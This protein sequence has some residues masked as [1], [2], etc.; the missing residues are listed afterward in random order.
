MSKTKTIYSPSVNILR[1]ADKQ[2]NY[3]VTANAQQ[4]VKS[5]DHS[6]DSGVHAFSIIGSY[7]TGKSSFLWAFEH[8]LRGKAEYFNVPFAKGDKVALI[9]MVGQNQSII[10]HFAEV[11][12]I[13]NDLPGNQ[14][15]F[16]ALFQRY[17]QC[18]LLLVAIDEFGKFLEH[19][20][21]HDP[22]KELYFVQQLAE[23][24]NDPN[25]KILLLTTLHQSFD[26]Y[27]MT[28]SQTQRMEWRKVKGRLTE[29][30]FNEP[31]EQLLHLA[32]GRINQSEEK[33]KE[34]FSPQSY[35][36]LANVH[37][38]F[39]F[40]SDG[41]ERCIER[42]YPLDIFAATVLTKALQ[43]YGQNERS[44]FGF[45]ESEAFEWHDARRFFD[46]ADVF[47]YLQA[48]FHSDLL[49]ARSII[50]KDW[51][52][53][54]T[55]LDLVSTQIAKDRQLVEKLVKAIGLL[56]LFG[57]KGAQLNDAFWNAYASVW[58][59]RS[60]DKALKKLRDHNIVWFS[61]LTQA[62]Q[63]RSGTDVD[64]DEALD[65][66][67]RQVGLVTEVAEKLRDHFD[68]P[69][70]A[71]KRVSYE[72]GT[73]R[74]FD[75]VI[76]EQPVDME[77]NGA[78][79]GYINLVIDP[80]LSIEELKDHSKK[81]LGAMLF[82]HFRHSEQISSTLADI[83]KTQLAIQQHSNDK[84]A[85]REFESIAQH[86]KQLLEHYVI[87][88]LYSD[89]VTWVFGGKEQKDIR[90]PKRFNRLL[91]DICEEVYRG[92]PVFRSELANRDKVSG[93]ISTARKH[94][95][96]RL[97][98][99]WR[100]ENLGFPENNYPAEK[101]IYLS[102][103]QTTGLHA[104]SDNGYELARPMDETASTWEHW[105]SFIPL[106]EACENFLDET[107]E[108]K[109]NLI[110]LYDQLAK[111]PYKLKQG[112]ADFWIP[113]FL[114]I[115][116]GDY[117]LYMEG[118]FVPVVN[119]TILYLITRNPQDFEVKG[120][121]MDGIRKKLFGKYREFLQLNHKDHLTTGDF[122]ESI[123]PFLIFYQRL[124]KYTQETQ[125]LAEEALA[126]RDAIRNA[127]DPEKTFFEDFPTALRLS[128]DELASSEEQLARFV[129]FLNEAVDQ[130]KGA[131]E[132]LLGRIESFIQEEVADSTKNFPHYKSIL[133]KRF[134]GIRDHQLL[135]HQKTFYN[136]VMAPLNDRE[137][138]LTSLAFPIMKKSFEE[139]SD[140]DEDIFKDRLAKVVQELE[141]LATIHK[142]KTDR[143]DDVVLLTFTGNESEMK[144]EQI[145]FPK[146]K[147]KEID[148][149]SEQLKQQLTTSKAINRAV[150]MKLLRDELDHE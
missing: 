115:K 83:E 107:R 136:R 5:I 120:L 18:D 134:S 17:E 8:S 118:K 81:M 89:T 95:F 146:N 90:S 122:I 132:G 26:A 149:L 108:E 72:K 69:P 53:V 143:D 25:R 119:E 55:A 43:K 28:L 75:F 121:L 3:I 11:L 38:V 1:D 88:S 142:I 61:K 19:A 14:R 2:L 58:G 144:R 140:A 33:T 49:T 99:H 82:G 79:D 46:L 141:N 112:F 13:E 34:G 138:W 117:A 128:L 54:R 150:L 125:R 148:V 73:L 103:L 50:Y 21:Q 129:G 86:H 36:D 78:I 105:Q 16:D 60:V 20:A 56:Q 98:N 22:E 92:V 135:A 109:Q 4:V 24:V 7:G 62:Y 131:Y 110:E 29:I 27:S 104:P 102:L 74:L 66:A 76:S 139:F 91:S 123:Q 93:S 64:F 147:K 127:K 48:Q 52:P 15:I 87:D 80:Q 114:F 71:A 111:A 137:S 100:V 9:N 133:E 6:F 63:F 47:D 44:L 77:P 42:L 23:F 51:E 113:I 39:R 41:M 32:A 106:W 124:P 12:S 67:A 57:M 37:N 145:R 130:L 116:R 45:L 10:E 31:V 126:F 68:F 30:T 97:A 94:L 84:V 35:L 59:E 40:G 70:V 96:E 85:V 101:T 65:L